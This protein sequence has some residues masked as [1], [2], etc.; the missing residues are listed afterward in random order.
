MP[1]GNTLTLTLAK[2]KAHCGMHLTVGT[3]DDTRI[4]ELIESKQYWLADEW[5]WEQL[6]DSWKVTLA[7]GAR[8]TNWPTTDIHAETYSINFVR[9]L[10]LVTKIGNTWVTVDYGISDANYSAYSSDDSEL[11]TPVQNWAAYGATQFEVWPMPNQTT[12][13]KLNGQR[14]LKTLRSGGALSGSATLDLDDELVALYVAAELLIK[15]KQPDGQA[16]LAAAQERFRM[17]RTPFGR[18]RSFRMGR[19]QTREYERPVKIL[20]IA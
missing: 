11:S 9:P 13:V 20:T 18:S 14:V 6:K 10:E 17:L 2:V 16:K 5:D 1:T 12:Y 4:E 8:Y 3:G 19:S 15:A 7:S